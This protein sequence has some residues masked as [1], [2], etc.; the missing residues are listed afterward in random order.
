[1]IFGYYNIY[2][3]VH[4]HG[5]HGMST[6]DCHIMVIMR[7]HWHT[8]QIEWTG[9]ISLSGNIAPHSNNGSNIK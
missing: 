5:V 7:I 3:I 2:H 4:I 6:N 8:V 1:M 9:D